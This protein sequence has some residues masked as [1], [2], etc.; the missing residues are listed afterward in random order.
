MITTVTRRITRAEMQQTTM[1]SVLGMEL[2]F[3]M[4]A[5]SAKLMMPG[6]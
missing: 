5:Q 3:T 2:K 4:V 6:M 1:A